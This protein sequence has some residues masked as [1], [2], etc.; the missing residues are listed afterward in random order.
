MKKFSQIFHD[1]IS[2][3]H[4]VDDANQR[5]LAKALDKFQV[6]H[7]SWNLIK[8]LLRLFT[9]P[10]REK[11]KNGIYVWGEVGV[12]KTMVLNIFFDSLKTSYKLRK[13]F[14]EFMLD[15]HESMH[16]LRA[17]QKS[18]AIKT[19]AS[20]LSKQYHI[21][22]L[23]ELQINN[24]ADA[25]IVGRLFSEL[26]RRKVIVVFSS[27]RAPSALF[28]DGLQRERFIPFIQFVEHTFDLMCM[29][30]ATDY[31]LRNFSLNQAYFHPNNQDAEEKIASIVRSLTEGHALQEK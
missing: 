9:P 29:D 31:R 14:H 24:I 6:H 30:S 8:A 26:A 15:T 18:D 12:G 17:C 21:I 3:H 11:K 10:K 25:M 28:K 23:D 16:N 7:R 5:L 13:H 22:I 27:N 1:H 2:S 20:K 4:M 19:Y